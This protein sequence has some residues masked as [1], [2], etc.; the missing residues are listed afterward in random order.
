MKKIISTKGLLNG[1]FDA[2]WTNTAI[3]ERIDNKLEYC[4]KQDSRDD[5]Q[6]IP[7]YH[8]IARVARL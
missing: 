5:I 4:Y 6:V 3:H 8:T 7:T 1:K 2:P